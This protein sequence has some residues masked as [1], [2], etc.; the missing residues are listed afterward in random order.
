M[1]QAFDGKKFIADQGKVKIERSLPP[2]VMNP[3]VV[4]HLYAVD[5]AG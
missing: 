5:D 2:S 3:R 4:D 1:R